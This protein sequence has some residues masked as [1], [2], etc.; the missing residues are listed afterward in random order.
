MHPSLLF[1]CA[2][3]TCRSPVGHAVFNYIKEQTDLA[4]QVESAGIWACD[5]QPC[6]ATM[7]TIAAK[8]GYDLSGH[9]SNS[10]TALNPA[11]YNRILIFEHAHFE[12]VQ[13]WMGGQNKPEYIMAYS[14]YFGDQEVL[15]QGDGDT[16][17]IYTHILD[18]IEDGCL[19]LYKQLLT[20]RE[21]D[22]L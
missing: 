15:M 22:E 8:R 5:G 1:I 16:A 6:D 3:N 17:H 12:P 2:L 10:L 7:Q 19:G 14:K 13:H 9:R 21:N 11:D 18:L 20:E 4:L